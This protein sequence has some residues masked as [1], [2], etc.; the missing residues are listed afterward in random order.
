[1][2]VTVLSKFDRTKEFRGRASLRLRVRTRRRLNA[3]RAYPPNADGGLVSSRRE[4]M[5]RFMPRV[6]PSVPGVESSDFYLPPATPLSNVLMANV[7]EWPI[8]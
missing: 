1:M 7:R 8:V 3:S 4:Q 2:A 6:G 5:L